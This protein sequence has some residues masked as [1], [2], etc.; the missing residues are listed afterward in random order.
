MHKDGSYIVER[1]NCFRIFFGLK[2]IER[3]HF[4]KF[5]D[6]YIIM[7]IGVPRVFLKDDPEFN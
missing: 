5:S 2:P 1:G 7:H 6:G 4:F 3:E